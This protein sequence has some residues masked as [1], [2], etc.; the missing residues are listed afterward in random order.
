MTK[1]LKKY[2][3]AFLKETFGTEGIWDDSVE[4]TADRWIK[5]IKEFKP[6][7]M[8]FNETVFPS[9]VNQL[10]VVTDI[11]FASL[12]AHHLFPFFGSVHVGYIPNQFMI[13]VSKIPRIVHYHAQR[14][15]TQETLTRDIASHL[16]SLTT[17]HGVAVM[18]N[19]THTCMVCRGVKEHN[20]KMVTTEMRG[21]FLTA[22][23][24]RAEFMSAVHQRS[25]E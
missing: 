5:A 6:T 15:H 12:C 18:I 19:S 9:T 11:Q 22:E 2:L 21:V 7:D 14:P 16:K 3:V 20:A 24:A 17:A 13:G 25:I 1:Q 4:D 10:I 23:A 8:E